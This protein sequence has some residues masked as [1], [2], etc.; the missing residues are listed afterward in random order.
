MYHLPPPTDDDRTVFRSRWTENSALFSP[1]LC[2][3]PATSPPLS[4]HQQYKGIKLPNF[5]GL[6]LPKFIGLKLG[7]FRG[8]KLPNPM[9][10][11]FVSLWG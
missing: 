5:I 11:K 10:V 4:D 7:N 3:G 9:G 8:L 6:K 1:L 2:G